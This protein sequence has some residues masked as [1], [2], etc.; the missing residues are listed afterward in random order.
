MHAAA[1]I[2]TSRG[3]MTSHAAIVA[4]GMGK[5]CVVGAGALHVDDKAGELKVDGRLFHEGDELSIDGTAGEVIEGSLAAHPSEVLQGAQEGAGQSPAIVSFNSVMGMAD[6][7]RRLRVRANADTPED[8][9][10]ARRLGAEGIGLCR[11]EHM[12]LRRRPVGLGAPGDPG[13]RAG[14]AG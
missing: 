7:H 8:A 6:E 11:T 1:G 9:E 2:L 10:V 13:R 4:R 5:P 12:F 14:G 3:G